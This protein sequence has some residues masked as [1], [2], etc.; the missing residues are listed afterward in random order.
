LRKDMDR[1][2]SMQVF[3]KVVEEGGFAAAARALDLSP[4]V[5]SR[6]VSDLEDH[7]NTRLIQ[8]TTRKLTLTESGEIYLDRLKGGLRELQYAAIAAQNN[9]GTLSGTLHLLATPMLA[10]HFLAPLACAW[11]EQYPEV[12]LDISVDPFSYL[13]VEEFDLTLMLVEDGFN[14]NIVARVLGRS[15]RL[16]CAAPS[17]LRRSGMPEHPSELRHHVDLRFP[18]HK[19]P[20]HTNGH[21]V[22]LT[23]VDENVAPIEVE[24]TAVLQSV[25]TDVLLAATL[26]GAGLCLLARHLAQPYLD[27]GTLLRVL[28]QWQPEGLTIYAALP[29][30]KFIP[31]RVVAMLDFASKA[32]LKVFPVSTHRKSR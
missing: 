8:R 2:L 27:N 4:A 25:S 31:A 16:M 6:L 1:L 26:S 23:H 15:E 19:A 9:S 22:R 30:R 29:T 14:A 12:S 5:V 7:L 11:R 3:E 20:G 13:R 21:R 24:M 18:W 10:S 32:A 28:P 17:Y